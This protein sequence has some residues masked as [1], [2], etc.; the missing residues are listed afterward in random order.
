M[1]TCVVWYEKPVHMLELGGQRKDNAVVYEMS[2]SLGI[3]EV[4]EQIGRI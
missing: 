4:Y 3:Y 1:H 2:E